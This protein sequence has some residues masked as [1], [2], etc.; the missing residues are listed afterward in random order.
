VRNDACDRAAAFYGCALLDGYVRR[1][2]VVALE[3]RFAGS[4]VIELLPIAHRT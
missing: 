1:H 2:F 3:Q 4:D